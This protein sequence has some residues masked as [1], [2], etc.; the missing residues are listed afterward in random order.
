MAQTDSDMFVQE[1]TSTSFHA[2]ADCI[3]PA[4]MASNLLAMASILLAMVFI[5]LEMASIMLA[6]ASNLVAKGFL[7]P[8]KLLTYH[9]RPGSWP[10]SHGIP[11]GSGQRAGDVR[12]K[13]LVSFRHS[14]RAVP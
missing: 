8:F 14:L 7:I 11:G 9:S 2:I 4:A 1:T 6:M 13:H 5:L 3:L 12:A 10:S